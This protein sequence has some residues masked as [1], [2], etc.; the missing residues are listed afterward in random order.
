MEGEHG[1]LALLFGA[2]AEEA[3]LLDLEGASI[4]VVGELL[5]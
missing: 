1:E 4:A 3:T 5:G 2:E